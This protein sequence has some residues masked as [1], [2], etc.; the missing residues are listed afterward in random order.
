M[1]RQPFSLAS[2]G[3]E[4]EYRLFDKYERLALRVRSGIIEVHRN[5]S[6][7]PQK[8]HTSLELEDGSFWYPGLLYVQ[9]P[10]K[11][12]LLGICHFCRYPDPVEILRG[13][14]PSHGC[15]RLDRGV[16]C[17]CGEFLCKKHSVLCKDRKY[18]CPAC[19]RG[20][21]RRRWTL[22]LLHFLFFERG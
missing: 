20:F 12:A 16:Q 14:R 3:E 13:A 5:G 17:D 22:N 15:L 2:D 11:P 19:A 10:T 18:R 8:F 4:N 1:A 21:N 7:V 6:D 9:P